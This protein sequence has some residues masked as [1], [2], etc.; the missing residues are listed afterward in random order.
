MTP[1]Q[2]APRLLLLLLLL[3][4]PLL[5]A[6]LLLAPPVARAFVVSSTS[7]MPGRQQRGPH[8]L[9]HPSSR[10]RRPGRLLTTPRCAVQ[11]LTYASVSSPA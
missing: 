4:A 1:S 7:R 6:L 9:E 2:R 5:V 3:L 10:E 11:V 8:H